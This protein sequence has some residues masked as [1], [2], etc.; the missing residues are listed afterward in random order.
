MAI[1]MGLARCNVVRYFGAREEIYLQLGAECWHGW[2]DV[3][4]ERI[5]AGDDVVVALVETLDA[6]P[7]F[8]DLPR[9]R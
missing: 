2:R 7:L 5:D 8:C 4:L 1:A 9:H 3:G 6:R